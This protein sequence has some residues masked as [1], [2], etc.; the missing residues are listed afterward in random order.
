MSDPA[1]AV[2]YH[3]AAQLLKSHILVSDRLHHIGAGD[4]HIACL[5]HH[6]N[7]V[8]DGWRVDRAARAGT[9]DR[10]NLWDDPG[11]Q[12]IAKKNV[13]ICPEADH[14]FLDT[15]AARVVQPDDWRAVLHREVH[16]FTNLSACASG[17]K[18]PKTVKSCQKAKDN[19][20]SILP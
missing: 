16:Y 17:R 15:R 11:G 12:C 14:A 13:C 5:L 4:K 3:G 8:C 7:K 1:L 10:R 9:H 18:P 6:E 19:P 20:P 2:V